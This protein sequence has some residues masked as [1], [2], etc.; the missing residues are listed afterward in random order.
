MIKKSPVTAQKVMILGGSS[1]IGKALALQL[2]KENYQVAVTGRR[3]HLLEEL[4]V[5]YPEQIIYMAT[6]HTEIRS[7]VQ[8]LEELIV[9]LG[10]LDL[11]ILCSGTGDINPDLDFPIEQRT[12]ALNVTAFTCIAD[13]AAGYFQKQQH[14][15][16]AAITS[17]AGMTGSDVAPA[18]NASKAYQIGYLAGLQ[19]K[20]K[21]LQQPMYITDIRPGFV[22]TDM[23]KGEGQFWVA[24]VNKAASQIIAGLKAKRKLV[25]VT[26]RWRLIGLVFRLF[27]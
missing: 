12:I 6:D 20:L 2:A 23:A 11:L 4:K 16:F 18:Y 24:P 14:G 9:Q 17:I 5:Q 15:H 7:L 13:W 27:S 1:G 26:K 22:A 19:K 21:K 25:Y 8:D 10:G 3:S